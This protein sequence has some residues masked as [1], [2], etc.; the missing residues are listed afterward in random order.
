[1][2]FMFL[3]RMSS[4]VTIECYLLLDLEAHLLWTILNIKN[5]KFK[6]MVGDMIIDF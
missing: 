2:F 1:M 4:F 6:F 5:L 3:T